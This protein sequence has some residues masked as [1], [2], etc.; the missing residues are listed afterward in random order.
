MTETAARKTVRAVSVRNEFDMALH[1][2]LF[3]GP[4]SWNLR[5]FADVRKITWLRNRR[6]P[7]SPG[8]ALRQEGTGGLAQQDH[9]G[10]D[11]SR[12]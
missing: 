1:N 8:G 9:H 2:W 5:A 6:L 4:P 7:F 10:S 11:R 12:Q 3:G